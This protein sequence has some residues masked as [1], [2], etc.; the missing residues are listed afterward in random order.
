M[1]PTSTVNLDQLYPK[2]V[3]L[4]LD[5]VL[6]VDESGII[7]FISDACEQVF[8]YRPAEMRG[9]PILDYLHPDDLE[10]TLAA[11]RRVMAGA[12]TSTLKTV[13]CTRMAT[14]SLSSGLPAG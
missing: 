5:P 13:T 3:H 14:R 6:V 4:L 9:T 12:P 1:P 7:V 8:G 2:L 10:R 11:A